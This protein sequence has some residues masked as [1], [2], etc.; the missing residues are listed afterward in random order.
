[1][2]TLSRKD[3]Y[4]VYIYVGKK[5]ERKK[6]SE[7]MMD[8]FYEYVN[9]EEIDKKYLCE[10]CQRPLIEPMMVISTGN[11]FC[12]TCAEHNGRKSV[13]LPDSS[14]SQI[15]DQL[16]VRCVLC[17]EKN[18]ERNAF[19]RHMMDQCPKAIVECP[20]SMNHCP[21]ISLREE[22]P[23]HLSQ[24]SL[25]NSPKDFQGKFFSS[26]NISFQERDFHDQDIAIAAKACLIHKRL[27][28]LDLFHTKLSSKGASIIASVLS[29][30]THLQVLILRTNF[31]CDSG[32]QY[33][34]HALNDN[35]YLQ[36]L[37][38]ND[39]SITDTGARLLADM[40]TINR[41][42]LKITLSF[43]RIT[44]EGLTF[45]LE[46]LSHSNTTLQWLSLTSNIGIDRTSIEIISNLIRF[47]RSLKMLN[48]E[49]C[50]FSHWEKKRIYLLQKLH[51]KSHMEILL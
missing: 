2:I 30:D 18:I 3:F 27:P 35:T 33:L 29:T 4:L 24:C 16:L 12:R 49:D 38:L 36:C 15:V 20:G 47:N 1:M 48:L 41:S 11:Q 51:F 28:L 17:D 21:W 22:L 5:Q 50:H 13:S 25:H 26:L 39:N 46:T 34:C 31:I 14:I 45:L 44:N 7:E 37:D 43:N 40:L 32:V 19:S 23:E 6:R 9:E 42:L 8:Q 10:L